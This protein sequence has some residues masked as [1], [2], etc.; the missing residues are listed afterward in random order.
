M[1]RPGTAS[2]KPESLIFTS[3]FSFTQKHCDMFFFCDLF[4]TVVCYGRSQSWFG[5][6]QED[7]PVPPPPLSCL[8]TFCHNISHIQG[9]RIFTLFLFPSFSLTLCYFL[10]SHPSQTTDFQFLP[11]SQCPQC[12]LRSPQRDCSRQPVKEGK[13]EIKK[14]WQIT[15]RS[16]AAKKRREESARVSNCGIYAIA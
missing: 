2:E 13:S 7:Y 11:R 15:Q 14:S 12:G 3:L 5:T 1:D 6:L 9:W 8:V 4:S 10:R 16:N